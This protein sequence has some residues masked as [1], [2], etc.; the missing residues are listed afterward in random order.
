[1]VAPA[2][3]R[4]GRLPAWSEQALYD[5]GEP[6]LRCRPRANALPYAKNAAHVAIVAFGWQGI[7]AETEATAE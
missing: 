1:M 3:L 4:F 6:C 2:A 7:G 5:G